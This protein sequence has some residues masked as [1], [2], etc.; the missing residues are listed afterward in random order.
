MLAARA[1]HIDVLQA[2]LEGGADP[3]LKASDGSTFLL[4]AV[5][6]GDVEVVEFAYEYD[7]DVKVVTT[8][9]NTLMHTPPSAAPRETP[10]LRGRNAFARL[11]D[12]L[13]KRVLRWTS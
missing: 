4:A 10:G 3:K 11:S 2:L 13:P 9:G 12:S 8:S 5:G 6:S 7:S 1:G